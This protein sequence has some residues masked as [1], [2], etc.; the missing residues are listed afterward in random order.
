MVQTDQA[1]KKYNELNQKSEKSAV[2]FI[3]SVKSL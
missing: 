1:I 2:F 3:P